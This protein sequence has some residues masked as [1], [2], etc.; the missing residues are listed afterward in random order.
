MFPVKTLSF[1]FLL[2][3]KASQVIEFNL[4]PVPKYYTP[5]NDFIYLAG[6]FNNWSPND[7]RYCFEKLTHNSYRA[8]IS[9]PVGIYQYKITRGSWETAETNRDGS[10]MANRNLQVNSGTSV[11]NIGVS[12]WD[13]FKGSH[14]VVGNVEILDRYFTYP[15]FNTTKQIWIYLPSDYYISNNRYP[16]IYMH[17]AQNLFDTSFSVYGGEWKIDETME[18]FSNQGKASAIVVGSTTFQNRDDELTPY[19][20]PIRGGGKAD[21]YVDFIFRTKPEREFTGIVGSSNG[22]LF[23]FYAGLK[24]QEIFSKLGVYSPSFWFNDTIFDFAFNS[25]D[26]YGDLKLYF[27]CG[28][29]EAAYPTII[30]DLINMINILKSKGFNN[31]KSSIDPNGIHHEDYWAKEFPLTYEWLFLSELK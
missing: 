8:I 30:P 12:D 20:N 4:F 19:P 25:T 1:S 5:I 31:I 11:I 7:S 23:T 24:R 26:Q 6:T 2:L 29:K 13:D 15:Q 10:F 28:E 21:R 14:S 9:L 27:Y 16:V 17:D 18:M 22:G 3:Y